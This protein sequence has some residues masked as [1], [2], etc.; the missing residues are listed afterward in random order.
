MYHC[1]WPG[2][3]NGNP[4]VAV[5]HDGWDR[6]GERSIGA[7]GEREHVHAL[8]G[9]ASG[10]RLAYWARVSAGARSDLLVDDHGGRDRAH[11]AVPHF[12][13]PLGDHHCAAVVLLQLSLVSFI[14]HRY[15]DTP[16]LQ[17]AFQVVL[18]GTLV[19]LAG[20]LI[21]ESLTPAQR[22]YCL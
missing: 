16:F 9:G 5:G 3:Q 8:R 4:G 13:F 14:R 6:E 12:W 17:G 2:C 1:C 7:A 19:F 15:M 11:D 21:G 18:G 22:V 20:I 10:R